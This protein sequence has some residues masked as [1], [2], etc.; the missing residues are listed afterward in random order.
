MLTFAAAVLSVAAGCD[1]E[2]ATNPSG[3][4]IASM[5]IAGKTYRLEVAADDAS[6][7]HGLMERDALPA[8][9]GMVFVFPDEVPRNFW[10][11]HTRFPL[12]IIFADHAGKVVSVHTMKPYDETNTPSN[13]PA[14][15]AIELTAKAA[16]AVKPGD[17]LT[18]PTLP[19]AK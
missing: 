14:K 10:M 3:L 5:T 2:P 19:P 13:G 7:E 9:H 8:D 4:P 16:A 18:L 12:D 17:Q 11:H 1:A 6:R 15:Y